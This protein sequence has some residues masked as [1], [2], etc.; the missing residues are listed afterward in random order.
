MIER[1]VVI[2]LACMALA[3]ALWGLLECAAMAWRSW[4]RPVTECPLCGTETAVHD[5]GCPMGRS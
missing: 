3:C 1:D 5:P 4:A 2:V